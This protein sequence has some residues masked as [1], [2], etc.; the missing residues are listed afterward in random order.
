MQKITQQKKNTL[1]PSVEIPHTDLEH[2]KTTL[3]KQMNPTCENLKIDIRFFNCR[4]FLHVCYTPESSA[5]K[6]KIESTVIKNSC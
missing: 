3:G 6:K 5:R 4:T 2:N 1:E